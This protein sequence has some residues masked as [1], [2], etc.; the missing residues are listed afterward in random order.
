MVLNMMKRRSR[1]LMIGL[2]VAGAGAAAA[3][4]HAI[5]GGEPAKGDFPFFTQLVIDG[6]SECGGSLVRPQW[7]LTAAH[8]VIG[9]TPDD[10]EVIV[11]SKVREVGQRVRMK[12]YKEHPG[13]RT[14]SVPVLK[15]AWDV[16]VVELERPVDAPLIGFAGPE[17]HAP[18]TPALAIGLGADGFA[19]GSYRDELYQAA[20]P[21]VSDFDCGIAYAG[22]YDPDQHICAGTF[23][24]ESNACQGDSG[25]PLMVTDSSGVRSLVGVVSFGT[26]CGTPGTYN[27]FARA[28]GAALRSWIEQQLPPLLAPARPAASAP[29]AAA[30]PAAAP[31]P[32][33]RMSVSRVRRGARGLRV[34]VSAPARITVRDSRG[35]LL[36]SARAV[37]AGRVLVRLRRSARRG[38]LIVRA[39]DQRRAIR[40]S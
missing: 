14:D 15:A 5:V 8:C 10:L 24:N 11:G 39:G 16:A 30:P 3:P 6:R 36:G 18:G 12:S 33:L 13:F 25:G 4:A 7:V 35:R 26:G 27:V 34:W 29:T 28:A 31:S 21:L 9:L 40:V 22:R 32:R 1:A 17:L 19:T 20:L 38:R 37:R 2:G 23:E